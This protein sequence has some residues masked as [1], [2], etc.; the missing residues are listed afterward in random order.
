MV[1][2]EHYGI[3]HAKNEGVCSWAEFAKY[4]FEQAGKDVTVNPIR[5]EACLNNN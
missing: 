2:I 5:T 1:Q 4:I 3:Y